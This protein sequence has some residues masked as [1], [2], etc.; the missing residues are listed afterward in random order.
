MTNKDSIKLYTSLHRL[1]RQLHRYSYRFF[2][3]Q[4]H[5]YQEQFRLL[6]LIAENDGIIQRDLVEKMDVRPSSMTEMI[7]KMEQ[8]GLVS[9][10][11][12]DKDQRVMHIFLTEQGRA[13]VDE[14]QKNNEKLAETLFSGLTEEEIGQMLQINEK[15][16]AHLSLMDSA[17]PAH[18]FPRGRHRGFGRSRGF[19]HH[20]H[21]GF[22]HRPISRFER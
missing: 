10:K 21:E 2:Q 1:S 6:F 22:G 17:G 8:F 16:C 7:A 18:D 4:Q 11:Q 9:R 19:E 5:Y 15:L 3:G 13:A 12:D 20:H 14:S